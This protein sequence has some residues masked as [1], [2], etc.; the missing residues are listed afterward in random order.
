M[1]TQK[2]FHQIYI[3]LVT[4]DKERLAQKAKAKD[5]TSTELAREA[6]RWYLDYHEKTGGKAKEAEI[7]QA[8][9]CATEGL[10]KAT[11]TPKTK[12]NFHTHEQQSLVR[13]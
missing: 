5:L 1:P 6:I 12:M 4:E 10:I 9:R 7:S 13:Q 11:V 2:K 3:G 8:I